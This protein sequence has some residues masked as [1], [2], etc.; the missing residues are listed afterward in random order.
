MAHH[1]LFVF[2]TYP[3]QTLLINL[4]SWALGGGLYNTSPCCLVFRAIYSIGL[5]MYLFSVCSLVWRRAPL[6]FSCTWTKS[7]K[8]TEIYE[9]QTCSPAR[10]AD[11]AG[12]EARLVPHVGDWFLVWK[13]NMWRCCSELRADYEDVGVQRLQSWLLCIPVVHTACRKSGWLVKIF[14]HCQTPMAYLCVPD[15]LM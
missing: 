1:L 12:L 2:F 3:L 10:L 4:S 14:S 15:L 5:Y 11:S 8:Y 9:G 13:E 7:D 6:L